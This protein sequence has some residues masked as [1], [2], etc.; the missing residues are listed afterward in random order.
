[1]EIIGK[2]EVTKEFCTERLVTRGHGQHQ[3]GGQSGGLDGTHFI[4]KEH[5]K[6][7]N[8]RAERGAMGVNIRLVLHLRKT[9]GT[10]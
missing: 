2:G 9:D 10:R 7:A 5:N 8:E 6:E 1:M 3:D 4:I